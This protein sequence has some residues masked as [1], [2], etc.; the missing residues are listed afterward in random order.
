MPSRREGLGVVA[1]QAALMACPIVASRVGGLPEVVVHE[2]TGLL[3][4]RD[5]PRG[6]AEAIAFLLDHPDV[7]E[8]F[9]RAGRERTRDLFACER[10]VDAYDT[11]YTSVAGGR[12]C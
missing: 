5:D 9:G 3:V 12:I 7:A 4:E 1:V 10:C 8:R 6:L 11:L 2:E